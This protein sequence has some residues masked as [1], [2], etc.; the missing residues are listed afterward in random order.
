MHS[1]G[2][3]DIDNISRLPVFDSEVLSCC[4]NK[5]ERGSVVYRKHGV[6]LLIRH[7]CIEPF[8]KHTYYSYVARLRVP[9]KITYLVDKSI[10]GKTCIVHNNMNLP[11][12]KGSRFFN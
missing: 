10:P 6:P 1:A 9:G 12:A 7:L 11:I 8:N 4:P 2:T 5:F 3:G